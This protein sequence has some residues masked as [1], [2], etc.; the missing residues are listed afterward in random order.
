MG[1]GRGLAAAKDELLTP[2]V[3]EASPFSSVHLAK[4][5]RGHGWVPGTV[6]L[7][8]MTPHSGLP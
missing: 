3:D 1:A 5:H 4:P 8:V 7:T 2:E 6:Q